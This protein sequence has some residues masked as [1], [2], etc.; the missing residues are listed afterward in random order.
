[1]QRDLEISLTGFYQMSRSHCDFTRPCRVSFEL[2]GSD[3]LSAPFIC[4]PVSSSIPEIEG[5]S[6]PQA[7]VSTKRAPALPG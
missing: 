2:L 6:D 4:F 3:E 5:G 7:V 1:M